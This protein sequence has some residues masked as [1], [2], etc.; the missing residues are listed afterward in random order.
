MRVNVAD[1]FGPYEIVRPLS[2]GGMGEVYLARDTRLER[3]VALKMLPADRAGNWEYHQHLLQEA[4]AAGALSHPNILAIYDVGTDSSCPFVVTE[5]VDG[6]TLRYEIDR[7]RVP[8]RRLL[9]IAVQIAEGLAA[10]HDAGIVHCD[11]KPENIMI[12]RDGRTKILDFGL[13]QVNAVRGAA[14]QEQTEAGVVAGTPSYMSPEQGRGGVVDFRSDQFSFGIVLYEMAA[15]RH[16][17]RRETA[18]QTIAAIIEDEPRPLADAHAATP[19]PLRWMVERCLAKDPSH[20]YAATTDL[21]RDLSMLRAH[22][23]EA[24]EVDDVRLMSTPR[25]WRRRVGQAALIFLLAA[26]A[27]VSGF[28]ERLGLGLW[29]QEA[30]P[31]Y[32]RLTFRPGYVHTARF[33]P[34]GETIVYSASWGRSPNELFSTRLGSPESRPLGHGNV[35]VLSVSS[36]GE[37]AVAVNPSHR[38]EFVQ[39]TLA[40]AGL[41]GTVGRPLLENVVAA[42]WTPDGKELA[43]A[44]VKGGVYYVEFPIGKQLYKTSDR[45]LSLRFSRD[46]Q[47]LALFEGPSV[48]VLDLGGV[49]QELSRGWS[50]GNQVAWSP[51]GKEVWFTASELVPTVSTSNLFAVTLDG[52]VRVLGTAPVG[53][54]LLDV[55]SAGHVLLRTGSGSGSKGMR[56]N[57]GAGVEETDLSWFDWGL[58]ADLSF[59]SKLLLFTEG[60]HAAQRGRTAYVRRT[61]GADAFMLG[62]GTAQ[63][64]SPDGTVALI[65]R[66]VDGVTRLVSVPI[67]TGQE[68]TLTGPTLNCGRADW[69]DDGRIVVWAEETGQVPRTFV[70]NADGT[71]RRALTPPEV[72]GTLVSP[73]ALWLL[74]R[75]KREPYALYPMDGGTPTPIPGLDA[76]DDPVS[77]TADSKSIFVR[78]DYQP[79]ALD[80]VE[81]FKVD[82]ATGRRT[83]WKR[84][85]PS[86]F[87]RVAD[88]LPLAISRDGRS[89]AYTYIRGSQNLFLARGLR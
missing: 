29:R 9:D 70:L 43:V 49:R 79:T 83:L 87:S 51:D 44:H 55:S 88:T 22:L 8:I 4:R 47:R 38:G 28:G 89:F 42:D 31:I 40:R 20:R 53:L 30:P 37:M 57:S 41:S 7:G 10:A 32:E 24:P 48:S 63:A 2:S 45:I 62:D 67:G 19:T 61:D 18:V 58:V 86:E 74:A 69:V 3:D 65:T 75:R 35:S 81:V 71:G 14:P 5:L 82:V 80:I 50:Y 77:W 25:R 21:A 59:D 33:A 11:M 72:Q 1:R 52:K 36:L 16:P 54:S 46:G 76:G 13:A 60:A 6:V 66:P 39:G 64:L 26:G 27:L 68:R 78:R 15:G 73:N 84:L 85:R 17:F 56:F 12:T 23:S 34:D